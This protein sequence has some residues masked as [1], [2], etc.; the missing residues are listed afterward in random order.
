MKKT[1][2]PLLCKTCIHR[3]ADYLGCSGY[4]LRAAWND[5]KKGLR[6]PFDKLFNNEP[7]KYDYSCIDYEAD[8]NIKR[9]AYKL[10]KVIG[11][12]IEE[13]TNGK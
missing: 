13:E 2:L 3:N 12:M 10:G 1:E 11:K 9:F 4:A 8:E 6:E 5:L 7:K